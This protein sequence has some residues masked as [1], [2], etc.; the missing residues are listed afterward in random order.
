M[1]TSITKSQYFHYFTLLEDG[2][3]NLSYRFMDKGKDTLIYINDDKVLSK[4]I[5]Y[6][7]ESFYADKN[8]LEKYLG[9]NYAL[10]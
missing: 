3:N 8:F 4:T 5:R 1:L 7:G 9:P 6:M 10:L 2:G